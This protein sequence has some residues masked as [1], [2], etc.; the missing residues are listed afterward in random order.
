MKELLKGSDGLRERI[1]QILAKRPTTW[2]QAML[3]G[4][5]DNV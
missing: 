4:I 2:W 1:E 3:E 5:K